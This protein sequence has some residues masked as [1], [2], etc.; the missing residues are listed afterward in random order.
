M[1]AAVK[2]ALCSATAVN[3]ARVQF[4][5]CCAQ[6]AVLR[7]LCTAIAQKTIRIRA[8]EGWVSLLLL[9]HSSTARPSAA[10][11]VLIRRPGPC[12]SYGPKGTG[13]TEL[14]CIGHPRVT[15][16]LLSPA[17]AV[18]PLRLPSETPLLLFPA[19]F[20][21]SPPPTTSPPP[22]TVP[23]SIAI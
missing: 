5:D 14:A 1:L 15:Q 19:L 9:N 13:A 12:R 6:G 7:L 4:S 3:K 11:F 10:H 2:N 18:L 23:R 17:L 21:Y 20:P 8:P 22:S 16:G